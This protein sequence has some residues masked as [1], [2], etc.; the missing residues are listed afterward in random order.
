MF[1]KESEKLKGQGRKCQVG[2][3]LESLEV[4]LSLYWDTCLWLFSLSLHCAV[5][6]RHGDR[7]ASQPVLTMAAPV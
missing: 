7:L 5:C 4:M 1:V 6:P 2:N 3:A